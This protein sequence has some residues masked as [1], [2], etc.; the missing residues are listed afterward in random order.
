MVKNSPISGIATGIQIQPDSVQF[1]TLVADIA[2]SSTGFPVD[3]D[4]SDLDRPTEG[5]SSISDA[6]QDIR[7]GKVQLL[8][9]LDFNM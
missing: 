7:N 5:F 9:G 6:I 4:E 8:F 2:P 3:N 1:G